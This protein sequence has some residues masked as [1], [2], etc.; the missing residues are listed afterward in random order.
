VNHEF[1]LGGFQRFA[2]GRARYEQREIAA[3]AGF[4]EPDE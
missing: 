3:P 1:G 2:F 4:D